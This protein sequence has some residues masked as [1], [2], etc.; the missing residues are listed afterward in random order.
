MFIMK[1]KN[2]AIIPLKR[3][4][5]VFENKLQLV[6]IF[7]NTSVFEGL[8]K[9]PFLFKRIEKTSL[10]EASRSE[11]FCAEVFNCLRK[12]RWNKKLLV[13]YDM[14]IK[15]KKKFTKFIAKKTYSVFQV[16]EIKLNA[17]RLFSNMF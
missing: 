7:W 5:K 10:C 9:F 12:L 13:L 2:D 16:Q 8:R 6:V 14:A 4:P 15:F 11:M 17:L 3:F 1:P